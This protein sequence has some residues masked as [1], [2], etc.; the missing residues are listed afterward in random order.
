MAQRLGTAMDDEVLR[1]RNRLE[2]LRI[3]PL[4]APDELSAEGA[5]EVWILSEGLLTAPPSRISKDIDVWGPG[6]QTVIASGV[7]FSLRL[8]IACSTFDS[9]GLYVAPLL[10]SFRTRAHLTVPS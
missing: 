4:Y 1:R 3:G 6:C 2:V 10:T 5:G 9:D 7:A 8:V